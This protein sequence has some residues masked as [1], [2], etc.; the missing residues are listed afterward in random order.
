MD[1]A[2]IER[3]IRDILIAIGEN[4]DREGLAE[5][6]RRV[7]DMYEEVFAGIGLSNEDIAKKFGK[8]FTADHSDMV[9]V[10]DIPCFSWCEHHMALMYNM[11]I[12]VGYIPAGKVIGLSKIARI[13]DMVCR[14]LQ[15]QEKIGTDILDIMQRAIGTKDVIVHITGEHSCMTARGIRK[16]G[17]TTKTVCCDGVFRNMPGK[18]EAFMSMIQR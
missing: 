7:A 11:H 3:A 5:T 13:A 8:C 4:P 17:T 15:L 16:N 10:Q 14:R 12:S 18:R 6:P 9:V 1:K 2:T